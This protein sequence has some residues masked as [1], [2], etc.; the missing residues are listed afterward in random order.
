MAIAVLG[1]GSA[2]SG[3]G[4]RCRFAH[5]QLR[6]DLDDVRDFFVGELLDQGAGRQG[7][8][9]LQRLTNCGEAGNDVGGRLNVVEAEYRDVLRDLQARVV[10][11]SDAADCGDV[12]EAKD[13]GKVSAAQQQLVNARITKFRGVEVLVQLYDEVF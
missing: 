5:D 12:V 8:H 4:M 7:S 9:V 3:T 1:R 6:V 11:C 10:Q 13:C 2:W